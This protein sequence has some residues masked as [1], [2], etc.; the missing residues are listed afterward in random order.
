MRGVQTNQNY[1]SPVPKT[2]ISSFES[3]YPQSV[4]DPAISILK[5]PTIPRT[6]VPMGAYISNGANVMAHHFDS[7]LPGR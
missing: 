7:M 3:V 1:L 5:L 6:Q 2:S 4:D